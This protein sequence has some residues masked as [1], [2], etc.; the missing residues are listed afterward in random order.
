MA[1]GVS[2]LVGVALTNAQL[3]ADATEPRRAAVIALP[4]RADDELALDLDA[5]LRT[6]T[7]AAVQL[8]HSRLCLIYLIDPKS[9]LLDY[10]AGTG[11]ESPEAATLVPSTG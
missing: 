9:G 3:F 6:I 4:H 7:A 11:L 10:V 5:T 1:R 8:T 2:E